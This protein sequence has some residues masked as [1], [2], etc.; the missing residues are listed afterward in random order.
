MMLRRRNLMAQKT[1][2][3]LDSYVHDSTIILLDGIENTRKGHNAE[4][5]EWEDLVGPYSFT[6]TSNFSFGDSHILATGKIESKYGVK[7]P[8]EYTLE[9]VYQY[10]GSTNY[11][12]GLMEIAPM[13]RGRKSTVSWWARQKPDSSDESRLYYDR[14]FDINALNY[15]AITQNAGGGKSYCNGVMGKK[16]ANVYTNN[17]YQKFCNYTESEVMTGKIYA[18]RLHSR[19]LTDAELAHNFAVDKAR[20]GIKEVS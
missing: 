3:S 19:A 4:A 7:V 5:A 12:I 17:N 13:F 10:T 11:G 18:I 14:T 9:I 2:Y 8:A 6:K 1:G 20:F 16:N 15:V